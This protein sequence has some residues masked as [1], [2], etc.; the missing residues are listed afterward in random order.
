MAEQSREKSSR[1]VIMHSVFARPGKIW[2]VRKKKVFPR[3]EE[4][5]ET[6]LYA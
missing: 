6:H 2:T 3:Q 4:L 1:S 5:N